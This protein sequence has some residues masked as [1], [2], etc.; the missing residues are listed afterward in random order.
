MEEALGI[1]WSIGAKEDRRNR[2]PRALVRY[3]D[4]FVVMCP[5]KDDAE[6]AQV[7]LG[8]WLA[9]RGLT[10]SRNKTR[11]VH[12]TEGFDFLGFN[13]RHYHVPC[14]TKTGY[15]LLITPSSQATRSLRERLRHEWHRLRGAN[16]G[17]AIGALAPIIRGWANYHRA[18]SAS[19]VF[20][21]LDY[22]MFHRERRWM[23][24][25]HPTKSW[26]WKARRYFGRRHPTRGDR[27]VFGVEGSG[28][29]LPKFAWFTI[30]RHVMVRGSASPDDPSLRDYWEKRNWTGAKHLNRGERKIAQQQGCRCQVCGE[31]LFNGEELHK[32][33]LIPRT[34]G[35]TTTCANLAFRH[36]YC[37]Q[38]LHSKSIRDV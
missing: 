28:A 27:W 6:R 31:S 37:H 4:D 29:Y 16:A 2:T 14:H 11:T 15:K 36:L 21:D 34:Q 10:L 8:A 26:D 7:Q 1:K 9:Q 5:S 38:Q 12:L 19:H 32:H 3:A 18:I 17:Q 25:A 24:H 35:G 13:V 20:H 33:H 22:W 30:R 23:T